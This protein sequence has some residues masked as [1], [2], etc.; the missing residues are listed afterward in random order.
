M[1]S[2]VYEWLYAHC[3]DVFLVIVFAYM[4]WHGFKVELSI[5]NRFYFSYEVYKFKGNM[6][7]F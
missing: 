4:V 3:G 1:D 2:A 7:Y 6:R 5:G